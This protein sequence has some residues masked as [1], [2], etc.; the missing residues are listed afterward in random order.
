MGALRWIMVFKLGKGRMEHSST[1]F[2]RNPTVHRPHE[3]RYEITHN[4]KYSLPQ[5]NPPLLSISYYNSPS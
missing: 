2:S 4:L 5:C 3:I 1:H